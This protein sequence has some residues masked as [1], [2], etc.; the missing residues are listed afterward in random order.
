MSGDNRLITESLF[1]VPFGML[2][3]DSKDST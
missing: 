1:L 2:I 3:V